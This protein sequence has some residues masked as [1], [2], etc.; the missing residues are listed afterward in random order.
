MSRSAK[1]EVLAR[2]GQQSVVT[3][4]E[5]LIFPADI[6]V[7]ADGQLVVAHPYTINP[8]SYGLFDGAL[9]QIDPAIGAQSLT[10]RRYSSVLDHVG[11]VVAPD[12][13]PRKS[14]RTIR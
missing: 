7:E 12:F 14:D 13:N 2:T 5:H 8:D 4:H 1:R 10:V 11:L 9:I 3:E 6:D